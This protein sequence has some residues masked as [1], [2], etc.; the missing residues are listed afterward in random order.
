MSVDLVTVAIFETAVKASPARAMLEAAEI[1]TYLQGEVT[2]DILSYVGPALGGVKLQVE[3]GDVEHATE[4]LQEHL[5]EAES[6]EDANAFNVPNWVCPQCSADVD[7]GFE[8]CWSCGTLVSGTEVSM[9]HSAREDNVPESMSQTLQGED[10][11]TSTEET[12]SNSFGWQRVMS[13][14]LIVLLLAFLS[15]I[16]GELHQFSFIRVLCLL[17]LL[18]FTLGA[19]LCVTSPSKSASEHELRQML[20]KD[21]ISVEGDLAAFRGVTSGEEDSVDQHLNRVWRASVFGI[22]LLPPFVTVY[23][24]L[25]LIRYNRARIILH[26]RLKWKF[27]AAL[28]LDCLG[29]WFPLLLLEFIMNY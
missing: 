11:K 8:I 16:M 29:L 28:A 23:A 4:L 3:N 22:A 1:H 17:P 19:V 6:D 5:D 24:I 9:D 7:A 12:V 18:F 26:R 10:E 25:L 15:E 21:G 20:V 27:Y 14:C 2:G 13:A